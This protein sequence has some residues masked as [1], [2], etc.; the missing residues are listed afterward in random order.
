MLDPL[1]APEAPDVL[2]VEITTRC[3]FKCKMCALVT[4]GTRS[5]QQAGHMEE[6]VWPRILEAAREVGHVNVNGWGENFSHPGFLG[7]LEDLDRIGVST[8]FSTNGSFLTPIIVSRLAQLR[9]LKHVNVSIESPDPEIFRAI[10]GASL[11]AVLRGL[12][13]LVKGLPRPERITVSSVVMESNFASLVAFPPLLARIGVRG[14]VMQGLVDSG[15]DRLRNERLLAR[16]EIQ[17]VVDDVRQ[18]CRSLGIAVL[19]VPH[20]VYQMLGAEP[21]IW[22][23]VPSELRGQ[24]AAAAEDATR[25]C[26]SPW[27]HVFVN[28]DG[29]VLPCC[30]CP[31]WEQSAADGQGVMG[32][33]KT[34]SFHEIWH[35]ERFQRFRRDLLTG[36]MPSICRTCTVT[37]SGR[38]FL[39]LFAATVLTSQSELRAGEFHLL[40]KNVG[41]ATWTARTKVHIGT[42]A[43]RDRPSE[44]HHPSWLKPCRV[45]R[46]AEERVAPGETA[47][48]R[49]RVG[50]SQWQHPEVFQLVADGICWL[51]GTQFEIRPPARTESGPQGPSVAPRH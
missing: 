20:L 47:T 35:G 19:V 51:P 37:S 10:R 18:H 39:R 44:L 33:L 45:A 11:N 3:N 32:D 30:N 48:F 42:A 14:Y 50:P 27:D 38:H 26:C 25:Q 46:F 5:S 15:T 8:N 34:H 36:P 41:E 21:A 9:G 24:D 1:L 4:G 7:L 22:P 49:F 6:S 29:L 31:P 28:K 2:S 17:E 12:E 40:A 43:P 23:E 13:A 16:P